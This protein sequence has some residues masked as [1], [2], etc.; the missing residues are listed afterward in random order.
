MNEN[1]V[2]LDALQQEAVFSH[3]FAICRIPH[4]SH[5]EKNLSDA[6]WAW[7][8]AKGLAVWQDERNNL[9]LR[10]KA[11]P[12]AR[13]K[14][15]LIMQAH[16]DMVCEK[17]PH[18]VHDFKKDPLILEVSGDL[19][20]TGGRTTLGADDGIGV[21]L[22]LTIMENP[23][24]SHPELELLLTTDEEDTFSGAAAVDFPGS[25]AASFSILIMLGK[26]KLSLE[27]RE[28][29]GS[30]AKSMSNWKPSRNGID[31]SVFP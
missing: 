20:G 10:R 12:D 24:A 9:L 18:V 19:L 29:W 22:G 5:E 1:K 17:A 3:F 30:Y 14:P 8:K 2:T 23:P 16:M 27:A 13:H 26:D 6:I 11:S 25:M 31:S 15:G 7:A 4:N 21:A 28:A